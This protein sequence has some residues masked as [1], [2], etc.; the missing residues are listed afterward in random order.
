MLFISRVL[1]LLIPW[2]IF[3]FCFLF[4]WKMLCN[5]C[6]GCFGGQ[7]EVAT[8]EVYAQVSLVPET[9]VRLS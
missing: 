8:D 7:A 3:V 6:V 1:I 2:R 5:L 4:F 9:K